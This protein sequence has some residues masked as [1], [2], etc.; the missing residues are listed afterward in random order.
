MKLTDQQLLR[1]LGAGEGIHAV[2]QAAGLTRPE[3]DA[4][5]QR[6]IRARVP[7]GDGTQRAQV[8]AAVQIHRD[9][10][11]IPHILAETDADL[12]FGMGYAMA[13]DRLFQLDYLRRR[14]LGRLSEV[15]G[16]SGLELDTIAR[17]VGLNRIAVAEWDR[18]SPE[19]QRTLEAFSAGINAWIADAGDCLPIEFELLDYRPH[20]WTPIDSLAIESEFRW[21]LTGRFPVICIPE[22]ARRALGEGALLREF[23]LGEADDEPILHPGEYRAR[24]AA[25]DALPA[26]PV[27]K[28]VNDPEGGIGSNNW[29]VAGQRTATGRPLLASDPHI[30]FAAVSCWYEA[31]LCGGSFHVAGI[32]YVG[33]P[34]IMFGRTPRVAW[35]ITNNICSLRDLYQERTDP[36]HPGCFLFDGRAE[37]ARQLSER[38]DV[39]GSAPVNATIRF[40]RNGPLVD[41]LLPPPANRT[42]PVSLKWLGAHEG[43]WLTALL[44]MDRA[45]SLDELRAATRS[46]HV[47]TFSLVIADAEG[48]IGYQSAGRIPVR[49]LPERGYRPGWDP[50]HQ[51]RGLIPFEAMPHVVDPPRGWVATANNRVAPD[52]F[53]YLLFGCWSSGWR[54]T[55]IRQMIESQPRLSLAELR[56][57]QLD[58]VSL[59]AADLA[60]HL[61]SQLRPR[62]SG[63]LGAA[64]E[65]LAAWDFQCL[66]DS[67][68]T[69]IFNV[70]FTHWCQA[71]ASERFEPEAVALLSKGGEACAGRLLK[72]DPLGWFAAGTRE[73]RLVDSFQAAVDD[74]TSRLGPDPDGWTWG[75]LHRMP[76]QHVLSGCGDLGQLL[77]HGGVSVRGDMLTV[78]NTG[79]GPDWLATTGAGYRL[80][81]DMS[82]SPPSLMAVDGQSQSGHPGS[83]HYSNQLDDWLAGRYHELVLDRQRTVQAAAHT[84]ELVPE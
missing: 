34:A 53:P 64:V 36:A 8:S 23:L 54:A 6:Q 56:Q 81:A 52:D 27:G 70:F 24:Q 33:M 9:R 28:A 77:D 31:H 83:P 25:R 13:Q 75:R 71:V 61:V 20:P 45:Q 68:A 79:S 39:R 38:I 4:W 12:F 55:R 50:A 84:L 48:R 80:V 69:S 37:P 82:S 74:L 19:V 21:Y 14:G 59:R 42:G 32:T 29:V 76:L 62:C 46:W 65:R 17:T 22:L 66:P 73:Q 26:E 43:G 63:V 57:M 15:L 16:P 11:G 10:W 44:A 41:D 60:P 47:P 78:C 40:S 3:F 30:A 18:L 1:R 67:V 35:G 49:A 72:S 5:W 51:W 2:C 58:S 7:A